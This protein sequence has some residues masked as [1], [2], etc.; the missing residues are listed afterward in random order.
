MVNP[1]RQRGLIPKGGIC[2]RLASALAMDKVGFCA[3]HLA[4]A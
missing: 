1:M 4:S 2:G 3:L